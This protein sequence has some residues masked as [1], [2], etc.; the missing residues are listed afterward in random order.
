MRKASDTSFRSISDQPDNP[1]L[2]EEE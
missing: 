2:R 1:Y